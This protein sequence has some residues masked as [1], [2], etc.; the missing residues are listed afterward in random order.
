MKTAKTRLGLMALVACGMAGA[1]LGPESSL[2]RTVVRK[3][4]NRR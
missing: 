2:A 1:L 3:N 4:K